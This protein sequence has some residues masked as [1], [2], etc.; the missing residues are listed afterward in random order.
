[1][2]QP[3]VDVADDLVG[4]GVGG[5]WRCDSSMTSRDKHT[6]HVY[7]KTKPPP[8]DLPDTTNKYP[9]AQ[10]R[11]QIRPQTPNQLVPST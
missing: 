11:R 10:S 1:M 9:K 7:A 4:W 6:S 3:S 5:G 2:L 8:P